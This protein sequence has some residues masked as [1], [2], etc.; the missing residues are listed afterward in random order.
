MLKREVAQRV[1]KTAAAV[2]VCLASL[3]LVPSHTLAQGMTAGVIMEKMP[4]NERVPFVAG[5]VEGLAYA[6]YV[7]DSKQVTGINCIYAWFYDK[8][9]RIQDV[10]QAFNR[11]KEHMP[12]AIVATM[13]AKECGN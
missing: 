1:R 2:A 13:V 5:I 3:P 4:A 12:G 6:R 8:K 9:D 10:Y 11:F 7:R